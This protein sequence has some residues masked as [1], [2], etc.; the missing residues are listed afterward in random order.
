VDDEVDT[1]IT[2]QDLSELVMKSSHLSFFLSSCF[3]KEYVRL[4]DCL[5]YD[6]ILSRQRLVIMP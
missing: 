1:K 2:K 5:V 6:Q 3:K 4:K